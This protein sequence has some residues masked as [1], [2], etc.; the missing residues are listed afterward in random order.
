MNSGTIIHINVIGLMAAVE[1]RLDLSL[2]GRPFVV[3]RPDVPRAVVLDLSPEAYRQG[4]RRGMLT[5]SALYRSQDLMMVRPRRALY[6][7]LDRMLVDSA[8][9]FTPQVE[10]AGK[11]HLFLDVH[12]TRRLFGAPEDAARRLLGDIADRTGIVPTI[13][14]ASTKTAA[15]VASRVFRPFGF[16]PLSVDDERKLIAR[17]P[18]ELLP[19]VGVKLLPRLVALEIAEIGTL[20]SLS[21]DEAQA[22]SPRGPELVLR[23]R[24]V[25]DSPVNAEPISRRSLSGES[26]FEPD[27]ADPECIVWRSREL[28][29]KLGLRM[30]REGLGARSVGVK[31]TYTDG[32]VVSRTVHSARG[33]VFVADIQLG[34]A[35]EKA[36]R[37]AWTRRIR[38]RNMY[39]ELGNFEPAGPELDLFDPGTEFEQS[40]AFSANMFEVG[41]RA[42][43]V[44][45]HLKMQSAL[46]QVH[47]KYGTSAI[48]PAAAYV[49]AK[50][51]AALGTDKAPL[52]ASIDAISGEWSRTC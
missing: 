6:D 30:R 9:H 18:V 41:A 50:D 39:V 14:V 46:D 38:V 21:M 26:I 33:S 37:D 44:A 7:Q 49:Y 47:G 22:I 51:T 52:A 5:Q 23:A 1:E 10:Q 31:L 36:V 20:A 40:K 48:M 3:A 32:G 8:M 13:A 45:M 2:R 28:A 15:K 16:A 27:V 42:R 17:Q 34:Q 35:V 24:C 12:G 29:A 4:I 43:R 11:G 19:G 25:D